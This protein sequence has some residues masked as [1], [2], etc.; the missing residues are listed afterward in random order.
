MTNE[1][2][3]DF[4]VQNEGTLSLVQPLNET[5]YDWLDENTDGQWWGGA[6]VVEDR[7]VRDLV[8]GMLREGFKGR[9]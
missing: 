5:T 1:T 8:F 4:E 7:Y 6:L 9:I 2:D 3:F